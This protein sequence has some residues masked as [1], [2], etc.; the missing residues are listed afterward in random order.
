MIRIGYGFRFYIFYFLLM[1]AIAWMIVLKSLDSVDQSVSQAAEEIMVDSANLLAE[2]IS[3]DIVDEQINVT[4]LSGMINLYATREVNAQI[5][6]SYKKNPDMQ[7]YVTDKKGIVLYDSTGRSTGEDF[8]KRRDVR[9]TLSGRYGAR[10]SSYDPAVLH[11]TPQQKAFYIAAPIYSENKE[12]AG[13]L[14]IYK[15]VENLG[16]FVDQQTSQIIKY[17]IITFLFSLLFGAAIT[18]FLSLSIEKLVTYANTLAKG[19]KATQ[20]KINQKELKTLSNSIKQMRIEL[21]GKE[22]I[23][24]YIHTMAHEL[25]TPITGIQNAAEL[26]LEPLPEEK[27]Q[28]FTQHILDA[29]SHMTLLIQRLLRLAE[30]EQKDALESIEQF[31]LIPVVHHIIVSRE[32]LLQE[33]NILVTVKGL[34][35]ARI[36]GDKVLIEQAIA[37]LLDNA[38]DFSPTKSTI[39]IIFSKHQNTLNI[40][41][42]DQGAGIPEYA[43]SR[44]FERFFSLPRPYTGNRSTGLGLRFVKEIMDLHQGKVSLYNQK[45]QGAKACLQF[46]IKW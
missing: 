3:Y 29:T 33:K 30:L 4:K 32:T 21:D 46:K 12:I 25:K 15:S 41:I 16:N 24:N 22:Y 34:K 1:G 38:I 2:M 18:W 20:P 9:Y 35:T 43:L 23:E 45:S 42:L 6:D 44:I 8:S 17:A 11:P 13:V 39:E 28:H 14:T 26:L 27:K 37:N 36:T 7:V 5:Y 10:S 19:E 31:D 40:E